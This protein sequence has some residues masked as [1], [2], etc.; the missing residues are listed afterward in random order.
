MICRECGN[1][2]HE[3]CAHKATC[4]CQHSPVVVVRGDAI[5]GRSDEELR[6]LAI[7][8]VAKVNTCAIQSGANATTT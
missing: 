6:E 8:I 2:Q 4:P 7:A 1:G 5:A 3:S